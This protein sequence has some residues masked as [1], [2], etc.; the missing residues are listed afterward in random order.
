MKSLN[1]ILLAAA[2]LAGSNYTIAHATGAA[3]VR[4]TN[5]VQDRHLS[6]FN[7]VDVA[8][9]IDVYIVQGE[10]ESVKVE[11]P[12][13]VIDHIITEVDGG[14]LRISDKHDSFSWGNL[15]GGSHKKIAVYV[16][17]KEINSIGVT[18]SGDVNFKDGL[19][20]NS[21]KLRLTG[22]GDVF[23]RLDVQRLESNLSGSGDVKISGNAGDASISV[24]GSGD[25]NAKGLATENMSV[26]ISGSGDASVNVNNSLQASVSGSGDVSYTGAV[27]NVSSSKSGSGDVS[28]D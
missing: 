11:A 15:F 27:K 8:G 3:N 10:T 12:A 2:L 5:E 19:K 6:G 1:K 24:S 7:A 17:V 13:D 28:R 14:K 25:F 20:S 18:G 16:S 9:S 26:H 21:L 22:S 4:A 23:G